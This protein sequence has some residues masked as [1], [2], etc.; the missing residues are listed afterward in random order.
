MMQK[1]S[2]R[3]TAWYRP[4]GRRQQRPPLL[5][6]LGDRGIIHEPKR[7]CTGYC[8][9]KYVINRYSSTRRDAMGETAATHDPLVYKGVIFD[10]VRQ[11]YSNY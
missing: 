9:H 4:A 5:G 7:K 2:T 6:G 3:T 8:M 11:T 10:M 1:I